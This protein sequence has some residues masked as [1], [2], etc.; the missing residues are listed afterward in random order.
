MSRSEKAD[1]SSSPTAR[2]V[3]KISGENSKTGSGTDTNS[4]V[5]IVA[6][7][8]YA[9][10]ASLYTGSRKVRTTKPLSMTELLSWLINSGTLFAMG[11]EARNDPDHGGYHFAIDN[12]ATRNDT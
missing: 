6:V 10:T 5:E 12:V 7:S 2:N 9:Y 1:P 3:Q 8:A 11:N 4:R